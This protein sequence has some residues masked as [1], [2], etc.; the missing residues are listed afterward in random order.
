LPPLL[1]GHGENAAKS[2]PAG[3]AVCQGW[4]SGASYDDVV[5]AVVDASGLG[6]GKAG[7]VVRAATS[8]LCPKLLIKIK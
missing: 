8:T 1:R 4:S 5:G 6:R 3:H 2:S 7:V